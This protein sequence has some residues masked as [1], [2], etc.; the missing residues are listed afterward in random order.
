MI[1]SL[2]KIL[3][4]QSDSLVF[5]RFLKVFSIDALAKVSGFLLL[6]VYLRLMS[7]EEFG[8]YNYLISIVGTVSV[9]L[10]FGLYAAQSKYIHDYK[11]KKIQGSVLYTIYILLVAGL[12]ALLI[13][14]YVFSFDEPLLKCLIGSSI[15][16]SSY[17]WLLLFGFVVSVFSFMLSN[18]LLSRE[19]IS[20]VQALN[21]LRII[22]G[23]GLIIFLLWRFPG[24]TVLKRFGAYFCIE[25]LLLVLFSYALFCE[26]K[27]R[28]RWGIAKKSLHLGIPL[29]INAIV[30]IVTNFADKFFLQKA[31]GYAS[32]S[33]YYLAF[34]IANIIG[35]VFASFQNIWFP[36]FMQEKILDNCI[37]MHRRIGKY[38]LFSGILLGGGL[39]AGAA[40][41]LA[42]NLFPKKY[43]A[44]MGI[45]PLII[46]GQLLS[47]ATAYASN[48]IVYLG[49][50]SAIVVWGILIGAISLA[51]NFLVIPVY[52]AI[53]AASVFVLVNLLYLIG[54][55]V[56]V[57]TG[58]H[59]RIVI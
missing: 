21:V 13:P 23:N 57:K 44:V 5:S 8:L 26:F 9:I 14:I 15:K 29:M 58:I 56:T 2:E 17:R 47:C 28:F 55:N 34:T 32:L 35:F 22:I 27:M 45:L 51:L 36:K 10:N 37:K 31:G 18:Y 7:Q 46:L 48:F 59:R 16:Y 43:Q 38:L 40:G 20:K 3:K 33:T 39:Y 6:P 25:L 24:N 50:T 49:E 30:G 42:L 54:Y 41:A 53:G 4:R 11:S 19:K 52:G 12:L 1:F